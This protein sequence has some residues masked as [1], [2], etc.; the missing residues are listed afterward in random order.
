MRSSPVAVVAVLT[1]WCWIGLASSNNRSAAQQEAPADKPVSF[2]GQVAPLLK[3]HCFACHDAKKQKG[4]LDLT[5]FD[6]LMKGGNQGPPVTPGKAEESLLYLVLTGKEEPTMPPKEAGGLLPADKAAIV[7]RWIEEGARFDGSSP[8]ADLSAELRKQWQPPVPPEVYPFAS[9][10][11]ALCFTPD[12]KKLV[13][14]GYHE[15]LLYDVASGT[16][17]GRLRTRA[18]RTNALLFLADG[19]TLA[20]AGGRPGQEGDVRLYSLPIAPRGEGSPVPMWNGTDPQ[21][22]VLLRELVQSDDE[23]LCLALSPDGQ[24]LAAGGCDRIVRIWKTADWSLE[25]TIENHADWVFGLAFTPD[26]KY[27]LSCSRDKT[28]KVWD[29]DAKESVLTF[30]GHQNPVYAIASS[31]DGKLGISG[32]QDNRIRFWSNSGEGKEVRSS[33][34][35]AKAIW[36]VL[37]HPLQPWV[38]SCS[39]D[40]TV[41]IWNADNGQ[42]VRTLSGHTD[43]VYALALSPDGELAASGAW[44]GE[45]RIHKVA[46]GSLL[47]S[48]QASPG[49]QAASP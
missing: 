42:A 24:R 47:R 16:L 8:Q 33:S 34:G 23:I 9:I 17:E 44:N 11:R 4:K 38:L 41:R 25:Q 18:E 5:T 43:F 13:A 3:E 22:E 6:R 21:A 46:D 32:G 12:G 28:A 35:H 20:V 36:K 45:V 27:L 39:S 37:V 7:R 29:L 10:V 1:A 40:G 30:P 14:G 19:K 48:F 2:M 49:M 31:R 26:G 15:L